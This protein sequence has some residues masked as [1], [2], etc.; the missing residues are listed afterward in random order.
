MQNIV[1]CLVAIL[2]TL[3]KSLGDEKSQTTSSN[4]L[5]RLSSGEWPPYVSNEIEGEGVFTKITVK[6][7][8]LMGYT[9]II[10]YYPWKRSYFLAA[11][12]KLDGS[13]AWAPTPDRTKDF[14]FSDP[15]SFSTKVFFHLNSFRFNWNKLQDI[16][17]LRTIATKQYTYGEEFDQA[18]KLNKINIIYSNS[19]EQKLN[20]L[21]AGRADLVPLEKLVGL[22]LLK[23]KIGEPRASRVIFHEKPL[24]NT[25]ICVVISKKIDP[26]RAKTLL[27]DFNAGLAKLR[28]SGEYDIIMKEL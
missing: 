18:A 3:P 13:L 23:Y 20:M 2:L 15:V 17:N 7:F 6:S 8:N 5:I 12:G 19:D 11:S 21:L 24:Q 25:P 14:F 10:K 9:V 1:F 22:Y 28:E 16:K 27:N 26:N 4:K